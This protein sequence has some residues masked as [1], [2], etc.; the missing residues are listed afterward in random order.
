METGRTILRGLRSFVDIAAVDAVPFNGLFLL[1]CL[2]VGDVGD[3]GPIASLME[4]FHL[5]DLLEGAGNLGI[6][7]FLGNGG[8]IGIDRCPLHLLSRRCRFEVC[9]RVGDHPGGITGRNLHLAP[10][11]VL[12]EYLGVFLF[13]LRRFHKDI[14]DLLKA[15]LPGGAGEIGVAHPG[16]GFAGEGRQQV[17]FRLASLDGF[18]H[19]L[20]PVFNGSVI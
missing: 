17:L 12:E 13:I 9:F 2:T 5:G 19:C 20:P 6:T 4:F 14:G 18:T 16:L 1:E 7:L 3:E 8:K 11:Q 10:F 15:F